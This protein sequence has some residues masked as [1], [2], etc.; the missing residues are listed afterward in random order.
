[1][2]YLG[3]KHH[4][5]K[6][7]LDAIKDTGVP[8]DNYWEP[9]VGGANSFCRIAPYFWSAVGSD[10][11][12]DLILMWQALLD[13]W[14][15]PDIDEDQYR[16]LKDAGPSALRAFAGYG[17]SFGGKWFAGYARHRTDAKHPY[18]QPETTRKVLLAQA[19]TLLTHPDITICEMDYSEH[20]PMPGDVV[21][22]DPP[23]PGTRFRFHFDFDL[24]WSTMERWRRIGYVFVSSYDCPVE[25]D[26]YWP[27][28]KDLT[29]TRSAGAQA[30]GL[31]FLGW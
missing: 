1:M 19:A 31:Y 9:F 8:R 7:I 11:C 10:L 24:F 12:P 6:R 23:Y 22:C 5:S 3:G 27:L 4:V 18:S 16:M 13:G 26:R 20:S 17:C 21:Y 25:Y 28:T 15:P 14:V 29:M 30:D 2:Q